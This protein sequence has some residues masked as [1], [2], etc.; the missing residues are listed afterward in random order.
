[1]SLCP[2]H[3]RVPAG[4][5]APY[6]AYEA[7]FVN[8]H[9]PLVATVIG[10]QDRGVDAAPALDALDRLLAAAHGADLVEYGRHD[11]TAGARTHVRM[12]YW[13]NPGRFEAWQASP[14]V[15]QWL[16]SATGL[17]GHYIEAAVIPPTG[18]DTL[19]ADREVSWGL[20]KLA[21]QID[22]TPWH[23][24]WGGTRDRILRAHEDPLESP[25]GLALLSPAAPPAGLGQ[26]VEVVLPANA[27][28]ARGGPDWSKA[29]AEERLEFGNSVY[30]A[31][32][33]GG[34]Y[35]RDNPQDAGCYAACLVQ[36]TDAAGNP[37][38]RNH[39]IAW[40]VQLS[41]IEQWTEHHPTHV[42]IFQRY[43]KMISK[44]GRLPAVNLYHEVSVVNEGGISATYVNC[45]PTTGLLPYGQAILGD[46]P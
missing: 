23:A 44:I 38:E 24:Y 6:E 45:L 11:D 15:R 12:A 37:L 5:K 2:V 35:L 22:V 30:P 39:M 42:A 26:H 9:Q 7:K 36:E 41:H 10:V 17:T 31:Y 28:M 25:A 8:P 27:V 40:F 29:N 13:R 3:S 1:M 14:A 43:L 46:L 34:H 18:V 33:A 16:E 19:I 4:F 32:V 20:S 21:E